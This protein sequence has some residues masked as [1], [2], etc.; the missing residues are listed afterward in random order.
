MYAWGGNEYGQCGVDFDKRDI[1]EP[2]PCL[3]GMRVLQVAAGGMHSC[4]L[5]D[6]GQV[7]TC[8]EPWGDFSMQIDRRFRRVEGAQDIA[9]I[10][11]GAFHNLALNRYGEVWA[12]GINDFGQL[13]DGTTSYATTPVKVVDLEH[14]KVADICAA[15]WHS[16][17]LTTEGEVY[18]WGRG[19]YGR[20]GLG[21][22]TGSSKLRPVKVKAM[23]GHKVVQACCGGTHTMVLTSEGRIFAW[24]RGSFGR[25]GTGNLKDCYN[26][27]EVCLPGGPERWRVISIS[28]GGRHSLALAL[29]DNGAANNREGVLRQRSFRPRSSDGTDVHLVYGLE[30]ELYGEDG[31]E[32]QSGDFDEEEDE[33]ADGAEE[34]TTHSL[35]AA[36]DQEQEGP[37]VQHAD[38]QNAEGASPGRS[39]QAEDYSIMGDSSPE[40]SVMRPGPFDTAVDHMLT[41]NDLRQTTPGD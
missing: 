15:G 23:E 27:V 34:L 33:E 29:P 10:E 16:L 39:P 37:D 40:S 17:A 36:L 20:L 7:Y 4:A 35:V 31:G 26:P 6:N 14:V 1:T 9:K 13:G 12:W 18:V 19:E 30:H 2:T 24:G 22:K 8:G 41:A 3:N 28:C 38:G 21:D 32:A 5:L 11:C 25:L